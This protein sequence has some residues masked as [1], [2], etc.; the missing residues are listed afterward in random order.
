MNR[1]F[2]RPKSD[3]ELTGEMQEH[4]REIADELTDAGWA[5]EAARAEAR[6]RFGNATSLA[7]RSRDEWAFPRIESLISATPSARCA[8]LRSSPRL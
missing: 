2:R 3:A 6:R 5:P 1:L 7:E 4:V 8:G